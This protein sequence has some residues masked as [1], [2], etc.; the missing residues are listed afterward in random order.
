VSAPSETTA[1][2]ER[3]ERDSE[4]FAAQVRGMFDRIAG[5]YDLM[6][7]AMTAGLHHQWRE[8]AVDR[9]EV[10]Q[11]SDALD[12]CC[13]TGDLA[14]ALRRRIGPDGRV[15]GCDFSEPMLQLAREKSG[16]EGLAVEFGWADALDLPYGDESFDAVTI[17]FGA[18]NLA[19]LERGLAEMTRVLRPGGRLVILE[20]TRPRREP[21]SSFYSLWFDRLV[22]VLG[23]VAGDQD[24]YSYLP[25]SVRSFPEPEELAAMIDRAGLERIRWLLLAGGIIAIHSATRPS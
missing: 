24:A 13:G 20:I 10:G 11:G 21:L 18:R 2:S 22:P 15:V 6:N 7:S 1:G 25:E 9:A 17:G 3:P 12:V 5:V 8:R 23:A 16:E 4:E 14:L 19:D